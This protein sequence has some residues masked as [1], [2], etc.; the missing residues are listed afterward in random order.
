MMYWILKNIVLGPFLR[1]LYRPKAKGLENIP[2]D[3]P[4]ILAANHVSFIDSLFIPLVV[5]RKVV[6]LGKSDYF[7]SPKTS[8]FF[9]AAGVIPVRR[10]GGSAS[11]GAI[12]AG[13]RELRAGHMVGIYPE[14]TRSP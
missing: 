12:Q 9:K 14:G 2:A 6:F 7:S 11:E 10:E 4:V 13:V 8:W 1:V 5:K 3:G